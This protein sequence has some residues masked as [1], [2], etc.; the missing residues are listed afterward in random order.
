MFHFPEDHGPHPEYRSEWWYFTGNLTAP[1]GRPFGFQLT[2][3]RFAL[4]PTPSDRSS[5]WAAGQVFMGHLALTDPQSK[6]FHAFERL[7]REA[8]G[9]AGAR[10][11]PTRVWLEDWVVEGRADGGF[12][13][14]AFAG[15]VG[16]DL[17]LRAMKPVVLQGED[18]LSQKSAQPGNASYYY[19]LTRMEARGAVRALG[20][21]LP[22]NGLVWMDR[23][24]G[25]SALGPNQVGWDWFALQLDDGYDLMFYQLRREDGTADPFSKGAWV[26]P[27]GSYRPLRAEEVTVKVLGDWRSPRDGARYPARWRLLVPSAGLDLE[28][29]PLI[30]D[31]ELHL[32]VRY[33]EGAVQVT[34]TRADQRVAGRG[35]VE[36]TGYAG[37]SGRPASQGDA[38][39]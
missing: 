1:A 6:R 33:W 36:L 12:R 15:E 28:V 24:W 10:A 23:E 8:L 21:E 27:A 30:P 38:G 22:V 37:G 26:D 3:F 13:I 4:A 19:S 34:G 31:Q 29:R 11:E 2:L 20:P 16:I 18:G 7:S 32:S 39:G 9:L 14:A 17:D 5:A 25:T 35:Y